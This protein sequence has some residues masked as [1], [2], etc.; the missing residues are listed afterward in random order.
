MN[1][2]KCTR[3][4]RRHEPFGKKT[5]I[6]GDWRNTPII[7]AYPEEGT[8]FLTFWCDYCNN[9]H[10][11]GRG[12]GHR[13]AHCVRQRYSKESPFAKTGYYLNEAPQPI[14]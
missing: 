11:H 13:T 12:N 14:T 8:G 10:L 6:I 2:R 5:E 7:K 4:G 9:E 3:C 1:Y